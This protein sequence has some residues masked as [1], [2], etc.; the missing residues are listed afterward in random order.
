[1]LDLT[2]HPECC[3]TRVSE[4]PVASPLA[5]LEARS[6]VLVTS[7]LHVEV[8]VADF[9]RFVLRL[10]DGTR[11]RAAIVEA[12]LQAA[13]RGEVDLGGHR[14]REA[15]ADAVNH[16]FEQFRIAGLLVD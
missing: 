15:I 8:K 9:D 4:R 11:D 5:R 2:I 12:T 1:M 14:P 7:L 6:D 10:L 3:A 16:A 13:S